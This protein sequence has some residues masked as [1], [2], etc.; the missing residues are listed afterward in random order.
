MI[1]L[2]T[3]LN[4]SLE[5]HSGKLFGIGLGLVLFRNWRQW[6]ADKVLVGQ[7]QQEQQ[8]LP[9][10]SHT[11]KI[12]VL[13]AAWNEQPHLKTHLE[14]FLN[15]TYPQIELVLCAGGTDGTLELAHRYAGA[16]VKVLEQ[17]PGE[18]KQRALA[19]A[20]TLAAG[21]I[22]YLTDADSV[23]EQ[24]ALTHLLAPIINGGEQVTTGSM[25]PLVGQQYHFLPAYLWAVDT[26]ANLYSPEYVK[27]LLGA[28]TAVTRQALESSGGLDF[29]APTGTDYQLGK[30]LGRSGYKIRL[31]KSSVIATS[32]PQNLG[33]YRR[34]QSRWLRNLLVY[35][36]Q[37]GAEKDLRQSYQTI[38]I[39]VIM[40]LLPLTSPI[41]GKKGL[42]GWG[43]LLA[44]AVSSKVRYNLITAR[45]SGR[46]VPLKLWLGLL[47]M[48]LIDFV[49]WGLPALDL[50][51]GR[52]KIAW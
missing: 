31:A 6:Q 11:P 44:Q 14:S 48:S 18:G 27:G 13:V 38:T 25:R 32:Y 7:L 36:K 17:L 33:T 10:L 26:A 20:Y 49:I 51:V 41:S 5:R 19:K 28:N 47:P 30:R 3:K 12:S 1:K 22:I 9:E 21:E 15:L 42:S 39:G 46:A 50:L 29:A 45:L 8:A 16:R 52:K 34:R 4:R 35:G 23:Y 40:T 37:Y 24:A 43:I 2:L